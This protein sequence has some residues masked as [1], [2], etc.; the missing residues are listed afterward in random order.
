MDPMA[1]PDKTL[2]KRRRKQRREEGEIPAFSQDSRSLPV[3]RREEKRR[4]EGR[5]II[6]DKSLDVYEVGIDHPSGKPACGIS[7]SE[8][9]LWGNDCW[10]KYNPETLM[11]PPLPIPPNYKTPDSMKEPPLWPPDDEVGYRAKEIE[12]LENIRVFIRLF[13]D[14]ERQFRIALAQEPVHNHLHESYIKK[15]KEFYQFAT[16]VYNR[17]PPITPSERAK[18]Y[19]YDDYDDEDES[20]SISVMAIDLISLGFFWDKKVNASLDDLRDYLREI[21]NYRE[22]QHLETPKAWPEPMAPEFYWRRRLFNEAQKIQSYE[23]IM[24]GA[25]LG[26]NARDREKTDLIERF[27]QQFELAPG[28]LGEE[29]GFNPDEPTLEEML[30]HVKTSS[31]REMIKEL[32][33]REEEGRQARKEGTKIYF[34]KVLV[35]AKVFIDEL[36]EVINK[37]TESNWYVYRDIPLYARVYAVLR[38][39]LFACEYLREYEDEPPTTGRDADDLVRKIKS[40]RLIMQLCEELPQMEFPHLS[41]HTD[42]DEVV[43]THF[44]RSLESSSSSLLSIPSFERME[45][46]PFKGWGRLYSKLSFVREVAAAT[47]GAPFSK[48]DFATRK[49]NEFSDKTVST[50]IEKHYWELG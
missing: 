9:D 31:E 35:F 7:F 25:D 34:K 30:V 12:F 49:P 38:R 47:R 32:I 6:E 45:K 17:L 29:E 41:F 20:D 40:F 11:G 21:N 24:I 44:I 15:L 42:S 39:I 2:I 28:S 23:N 18:D 50:Y 26:R 14:V 3:L 36:D 33:E 10:G 19:D 27:K 1:D 5:H 16:K 22:I 8:G 43:T 4:Q 48:I 37:I 13:L 46:L